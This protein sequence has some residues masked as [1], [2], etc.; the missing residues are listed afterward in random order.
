MRNLAQRSAQAARDTST[1]I[2][3]TVARVKNGSDIATKLD[4]DFREID[5]GARETGKLAAEIS[6]ATN[7]QAQ[8]VDQVNT[9]VAQM[10]K[11][12]QANAASAEECASASE[13]LSAQSRTLKDMVDG[14]VALVMGDGGDSRRGPAP[15]GP[16]ARKAAPRP[17]P[18]SRGLPSSTAK[19][20]LP[21]PSGSANNV[22][23]PSEV[24]PLDGDSDFGD[25]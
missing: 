12:T 2:E 4:S 11:V 23:R 15:S 6:S 25:F 7:E 18:A 5:S 21:A 16:A 9:A 3:S 13:R 10:D 14:L 22:M 24:I 8:G 19:R 20:R 17:A 1:L